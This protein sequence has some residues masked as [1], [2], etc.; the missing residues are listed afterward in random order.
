[1]THCVPRCARVVVLMTISFLSVSCSVYMESTRP[2]PVDLED[3]QIGQSRDSVL[4]RLGAPESSAKESDGAN[5][6]F[7][8][9]YTKGYGAV[10]KIPIAVA[11]G[12]A[13]FFTIGL[14]EV[15]LTP[16][17]GVTKNAKH[18]VA[19]CYK[20]NRIARVATDTGP[21][22]ES[23]QTAL[24]GAPQPLPS[25]AASPQPA[26]TPAADNSS[27]VHSFPMAA[28]STG[29]LNGAAPL[30]QPSPAAPAAAASPTAGVAGA[31]PAAMPTPSAPDPPSGD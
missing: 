31:N 14:A 23:A 15:L 16:A 3:Y 26:T 6:D 10:G 24:S 7:Y 13:D 4:E 19:F 5:C 2:T 21:G 12:A 27:G 17:E 30:A 18:P 9:L 25:P 8:K 28:V 29:T 20:D 11:E 1:M 22:A